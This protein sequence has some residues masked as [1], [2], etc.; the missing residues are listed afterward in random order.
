MNYETESLTIKANN[1][2]LLDELHCANNNLTRLDLSVVPNLRIL[3]CASNRLTQLNL[4]AV[5]NL[6]LLCCSANL[7]ELYYSNNRLAQLDL[8]PNLR[9]L[10]CAYN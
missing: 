1:I 3:N 7:Q 9:I 6:Q 2:H 8:L 4:L 5:C 10:F